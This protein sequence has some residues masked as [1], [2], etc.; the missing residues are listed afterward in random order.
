MSQGFIKEKNLVYAQGLSSPLVAKS[1]FI[2]CVRIL[3]LF[4]MQLVTQERLLSI[5]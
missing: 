2:S 4:L 3:V 1:T 5:E